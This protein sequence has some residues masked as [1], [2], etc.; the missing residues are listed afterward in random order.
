MLVISYSCLLFSVK[1]QTQ[2]YSR[3]TPNLQHPNCSIFPLYSA[4]KVTEKRLLISIAR[5][6]LFH[7][8]L[9]PP[10]KMLHKHFLLACLF[11]FYFAKAAII[12]WSN[13]KVEISPLLP[14]DDEDLENLVEKLEVEKVFLFK[15]VLN[16]GNTMVPKNL[17]DVMN[18]FYSSFNPNGNVGTADAVGKDLI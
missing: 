5:A 16:N 9:F 15:V 10:T 8:S 18:G 1:I 11:Q 7:R 6:L 14:F 12:L 2:I 17:R 4:V 3:C 13:K